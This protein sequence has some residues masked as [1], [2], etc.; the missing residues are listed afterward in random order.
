MP[1][2]LE[3]EDFDACL[4]DGEVARQ[5]WLYPVDSPLLLPEQASYCVAAN[6]G[7]GPIGDICRCLSIT[8][9]AMASSDVGRGQLA[10]G[11][12][13]DARSAGRGRSGVDI[14]IGRWVA[15]VP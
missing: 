5:Y 6:S 13:G 11:P 12:A 10:V 3:A 7:S 14:R 9:S 8:S 15:H 1:V 4:T 2:V